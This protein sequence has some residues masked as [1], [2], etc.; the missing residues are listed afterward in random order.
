MWLHIKLVVHESPQISRSPIMEDLLTHAQS[1]SSGLPFVDSARAS[2]AA[3]MR[4]NGAGVNGGHQGNMTPLEA[5]RGRGFGSQGGPFLSSQVRWQH[6]WSE[7]I[8]GV[9]ELL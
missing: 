2:V 6:V 4:V 9:C 8:D 5:C 3:R 7:L 1:S